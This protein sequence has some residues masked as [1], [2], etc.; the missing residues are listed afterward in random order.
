MKIDKD[1][2]EYILMYIW[3]HKWQI[4]FISIFAIGMLPGIIQIISMAKIALTPEREKPPLPEGFY[5]WEEV[6][7]TFLKRLKE[8]ILS[9][10]KKGNSVVFIGSIYTPEEAMYVTKEEIMEFNHIVEMKHADFNA[11][12]LAKI[13]PAFRYRLEAYLLKDKNFIILVPE[14]TDITNFFKI[15]ELQKII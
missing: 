5:E 7:G 10:G 11:G 13:N 9:V 14:G 4:L 2:A 15:E 6:N 1:D 3:Y 12:I 8:T